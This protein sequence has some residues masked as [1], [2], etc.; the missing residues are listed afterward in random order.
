[1]S[2]TYQDKYQIV[3]ACNPKTRTTHFVVNRVDKSEDTQAQENHWFYKAAKS[4]VDITW[5]V[6]CF[7]EPVAIWEL[8]EEI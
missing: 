4:I 3:L 8:A 1:M 2:V 7:F 6:D 5:L